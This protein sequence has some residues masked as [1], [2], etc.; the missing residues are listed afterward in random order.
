MALNADNGEYVWHFQTT[1]GDTWDFTATQPIILADLEIEG[2]ER[3]VLMQAPKNGFFY[4][5]D[6]KTGEFIDAKPFTYQNWAKGLDEKGRPIEQEYA[7]YD[8]SQAVQISPGAYGGHNW[9]P[10]S[11]SKATGLVYIP[12][13]M[14]AMAYSSN[15]NYK[16]N[17]VGGAGSGNGW[18]VSFADKLYAPTRFDPEGPNP[19]APFGRL[20]AY[21]PVAQKEV[22]AKR[23]P[24]H[25]NGGVLST[26]SGLVFQ[27]DCEGNFIAYDGE[28]GDELWKQDVRSGVIAAPMT[29]TVDGEQY[30]TLAVG[31]GGS[32]G[33]G[34]RA[35]PVIHPGTIY[36]YKL[37][38][39]ATPP[40]KIDPSERSFTSIKPEGSPEQIGHGFDL[41]LKYCI[42]CH[43]DG[44]GLGGGILPDLVSSS[45]GVFNNY[46]NIVLEGALLQNG[47]PK[48]EGR[49]SEDEVND[50][51]QCMLYMADEIG[52]NT[53][54]MTLIT[55]L[56]G[57]QYQSDVKIASLKD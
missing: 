21:D 25:W 42:A 6:R 48:F 50:I 10:M 55:N 46:N 11:Y 29:Y 30:I 3:K 41:Y 24:L 26:A 9:H 15:P 37:G 8:P 52:K 40:A 45:D 28:T 34:R 32:A 4:V 19:F 13:A 16:F 31:W 49:L 27:G 53:D 14:I 22:W 1:P 12:T 43:G 44:F 35:V 2:E 39:T 51:K 47:M 18:N 54:F 36:T 5:L 20:V 57:M 23:Q 56:A 38:G 17:E 33:L 7:R